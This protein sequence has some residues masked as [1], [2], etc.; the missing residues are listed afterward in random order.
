MSK[1]ESE[2]PN[3]FAMPSKAPLTIDITGQAIILGTGTSVGV[4]A[5][6][7]RC[8]VCRSDHWGNKRTRCS[9]LFGLPG[10]NLLVDTSPD[11]RQQLL[12]EGIGIVHAVVYTHEH[13]DHIFGMDDLRL[14]Q[15]YLGGPV[16]IYCRPRVH[17]RLRQSFDYV[18]RG[19]EQTHTG[20]VPAVAVHEIDEQPFDVLGAVV[21]PIPLD[22]GPRFGV[23]GFRIGN[24]AYCT[25]VK[26]IPPGSWSLLE[27]L[28]SLVL[29][30]L[31]PEP[32]PT[33]MSL[34]E[35]VAAARRIAARQTYLTHMSCRIDYES[36][37][38]QLP[39][40]I[41][42]AHDGLRIDLV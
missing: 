25:D 13:A 20:A 1:Y 9:A 34:D 30:A 39:R 17:E 32:H 11:M 21:Q 3:G 22:H 4:P 16:P 42:L 40:G 5:L 38:R 28:D 37:C 15:F 18:F 31:R 10:G 35:A 24:V 14:F 7:C 12:R 23:L 27:G 19:G 41:T 29:S 33:H 8:P 36:T 6:G 26:R 2:L